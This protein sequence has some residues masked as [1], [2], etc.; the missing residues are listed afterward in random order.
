MT[1]KLFSPGS[2]RKS[3]NENT[4][5]NFIVEIKNISSLV[6]K[7]KKLKKKTKKE[8]DE[9][10]GWMLYYLVPSLIAFFKVSSFQS[11]VVIP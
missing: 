7:H 8:N 5:E 3:R 11:G 1:A 10:D 6:S 2:K 9:L 4:T